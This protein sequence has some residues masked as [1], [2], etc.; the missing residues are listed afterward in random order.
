MDS[1][2][3]IVYFLIWCAYDPGIALSTLIL[4]G[5]IFLV[6]NATRMYKWEIYFE[7]ELRL[8]WMVVQLY[9]ATIF[10][11]KLI[12]S[13]LRNELWSEKHTLLCKAHIYHKTAW[14]TV[15]G[16]DRISTHSKTLPHLTADIMVHSSWQF[17]V[18]IITSVCVLHK[19]E[20][21]ESTRRLWDRNY[22][23]HFTMISYLWI[24]GQ[25]IKM[26][27]S[28]LLIH[29]NVNGDPTILSGWCSVDGNF[30][31]MI[32]KYITLSLLQFQD[33]QFCYS[34]PWIILKGRLPI[35]QS[36][37]EAIKLKLL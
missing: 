26:L 6:C 17:L 25:V 19:W 32:L 35:L 36:T 23:N 5:N 13:A 10:T 2:T 7:W 20:I 11:Q 27:L 1:F 8:Q 34:C 12:S 24:T 14:G 18:W 16:V 21:N 31:E 15:G 29:L 4:R 33:Y 37:T 22:Q 28:F 3:Q 9:L 30:F